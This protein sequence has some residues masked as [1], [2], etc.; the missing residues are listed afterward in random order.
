VVRAA[1]A[2]VAP[3]V[4][5]AGAGTAAADPCLATPVCPSVG[6]TPSPTVSPSP[7]SSPTASPTSAPSQSPSPARAATASHKARPRVTYSAAPGSTSN[8]VTETIGVGAIR[9]T[10]DATVPAAPAADVKKKSGDSLGLIVK[11]VLGGA[12]LLLLAGIGGLYA[13]RHPHAH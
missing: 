6:A 10:L 13:T 3:V 11:L 12:V 9:G 4:L 5:L 7:S 2:L 1:L 8:P